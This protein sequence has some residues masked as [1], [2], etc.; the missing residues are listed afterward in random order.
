MDFVNRDFNAAINIRRWAVLENRPPEWTRGNFVGQ[1][2]KV[3]VYE[4][5]LEEIVRG[6]PRNA[7]R[8]LHTSWKRYV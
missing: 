4:T 6:P 1:S 5:K 7:G 2:R 3:E 8:R